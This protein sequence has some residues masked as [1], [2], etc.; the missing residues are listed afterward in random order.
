[1]NR[2]SALLIACVASVSAFCAQGRPIKLSVIS[3]PVRVHLVQSSTMPDMHTSLVEADIRLIFRG[4]NK[5]WE[6]AAI[7]LEIES[8]V[9]TSATMMAP[10]MRLKSESERVKSMISKAKF[11]PG[12]LDICYVRDVTP[13]GFYYGEPMVVKETAKLKTVQGGRA[14]QLLRVTSHEIGHALGL[15]HRDDASGL[16]HPGVAGLLLNQVEVATARRTAQERLA[17]KKSVEGNSP[18]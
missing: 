2:F 7:R 14:E 6:Q 17:K 18:E 1:M 10:E 16:M 12:D 4:V 11:S 8:I 15:Q 3:L 13:N 9:K 5:I